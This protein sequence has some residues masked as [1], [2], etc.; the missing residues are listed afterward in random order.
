MVTAPVALSRV[1]TVPVGEVS[2]P[3]AGFSIRLPVKNPS[4]ATAVFDGAGAC[5]GR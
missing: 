3:M 4:R 1:A 2:T 5:P